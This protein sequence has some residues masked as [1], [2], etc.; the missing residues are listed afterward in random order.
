MRNLK[1]FACGLAV[2]SLLSVGVATPSQAFRLEADHDNGD[3][4]FSL[5]QTDQKLIVSTAGGGFAGLVGKALGA[6]PGLAGALGSFGGSIFEM[7]ICPDNQARYISYKT[8]QVVTP[9]APEAEITGTW[10][11]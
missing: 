6:N 1:N 5:N 4:V 2:A 7:G 9:H 10:C 3:H 11:H 8:N